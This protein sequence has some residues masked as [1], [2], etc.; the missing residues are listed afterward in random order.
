MKKLFKKFIFNSLFRVLVSLVFDAFV[1][2]KSTRGL[3][4]HSADCPHAPLVERTQRPAAAGN[5]FK[6]KIAIGCI[7]LIVVYISLNN[8]LIIFIYL[9][10]TSAKSSPAAAVER[11]SSLLQQTRRYSEIISFLKGQMRAA[12]DSETIADSG[13]RILI[14]PQDIEIA[15]LDL[16]SVVS[17][18]KLTFLEDSYFQENDE[19]PNDLNEPTNHRGNHRCVQPKLNPFDKNIMQFVKKESTLRCNPKKNWIGKNLFNCFISEEV[20]LDY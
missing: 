19:R 16:K 11:N 7:F 5:Y 10:S 13:H 12:N 17:N 3:W 15:G 9:K 14:D 4:P 18:K 6:F 8:Y 2:I 20:S 1:L